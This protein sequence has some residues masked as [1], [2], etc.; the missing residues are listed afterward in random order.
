MH[1][2]DPTF[3]SAQMK[4]YFGVTR[5][6]LS[7]WAIQGHITPSARP[8]GVRASVYSLGDVVRIFFVTELIAKGYSTR[9][10]LD[11]ETKLHGMLVEKSIRVDEGFTVLLDKRDRFL[12][13]SGRWWP[14][15]NVEVVKYAVS[16]SK[17]FEKLAKE[18]IIP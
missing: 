2:T 17:L 3:S 13:V 9:K 6:Q 4:A 14:E 11:L 8:D 15:T 10:A 5:R 16:F 18:G 12:L 1:F 7:Y